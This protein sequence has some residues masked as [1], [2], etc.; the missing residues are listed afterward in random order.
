[1][2]ELLLSARA[3]VDAADKYGRD[4]GRVLRAFFGSG[5]DEV[6][7]GVC[8]LAACFISLLRDVEWCLLLKDPYLL[9]LDRLLEIR[10]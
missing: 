3:T 8:R 2:V 9:S 1:M 6:T 7:G 10:V 5:S 4:P